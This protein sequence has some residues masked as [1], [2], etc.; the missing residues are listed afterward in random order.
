MAEK[1]AGVNAIMEAIHGRRKVQ[2]IFVQEGRG[3]KKVQ[4]LIDLASRLGIYYQ[5]VEKQRL[6]H[7][8]TLGNHQGIVAQVEDYEYA[9]LDEMLENAAIKG[10]EPFLIMLDGIE[11]PQNLGS[12]IRTA[13]CAGVHGIILPRHHACEVTS[14]VSRASAGAIEHVL[15]AQETNLVNTIKYL[16]ERGFWVT[17]A[18]MDG[19]D[20]YHQVRIPSPTVLVIGGEGQG[21]RRLVK[22]NCDL[23]VRIPMIGSVNSLNASVAAALVIYEVLRQRFN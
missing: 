14:A 16:K 12:I 17:G 19:S 18:D 6:D 8:Y 10:E 11:D 3:G 23:I 21:M 15:I 4:D 7:M 13:E 22:E 2:K 5:Y 1:I 9:S 20:L